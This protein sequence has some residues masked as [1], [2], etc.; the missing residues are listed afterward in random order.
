MEEKE[1]TEK[2]STRPRG[3]HTVAQFRTV[4]RPWRGVPRSTVGDDAK[5]RAGN[6]VLQ[7]GLLHHCGDLDCYWE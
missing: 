1:K 7:N 5:Q 6:K 2:G 3:T 4:K